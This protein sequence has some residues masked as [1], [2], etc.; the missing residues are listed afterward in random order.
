MRKFLEKMAVEF[1]RHDGNAVDFALNHSAYTS[2]HAL[3]VVIR[4][5]D[6]HFVAAMDGGKLET[7]H[8]LGKKRVDDIRDDQREHLAASGNQRSR[9]AI[10]IITKLADGASHFLRRTRADQF[11]LIN[12]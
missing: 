7:L 12:G 10:G 5:G 9:L 1:R 2:T 8:Q 6:D 11:A 4:V 3:G